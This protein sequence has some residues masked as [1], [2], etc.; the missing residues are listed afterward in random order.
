MPSV[1]VPSVKVTAPVGVAPKGSVTFAVKV[2]GWPKVDGF[3]EEVSVVVVLSTTLSAS[4][5]SVPWVP[6]LAW[7]YSLPWDGTSHRGAD[8]IGP[9][10][11]SSTR[12]VPG[13]VPSLFQ[14][15]R[16]W[17]PSSALKNATPPTLVI[18]PGPEPGVPG[19]MSA[20]SFTSGTGCPDTLAMKPVHSSGPWTP[21]SA[22]KN[23]VPPTLV[24]P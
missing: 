5:S 10:E 19:L 17:A 13:A 18:H 20:T 12:A 23:A 24:M 11:M 9:G 6:S 4:H 15:S 21:S 1:L 8:P 14:T 22:L 16:P 3:F 7:R 2:S